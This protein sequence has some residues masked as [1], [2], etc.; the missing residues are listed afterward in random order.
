M[1]RIRPEEPEEAGVAPETPDLAQLEAARTLAND[2]RPMLKDAG[3][4]DDQI[5]KW[6]ETYIA[7]EGSG[8]VD[9]FVAWIR[10]LQE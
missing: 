1:D 2:A 8:D 6:A 5:E 9:T 4:D 3:F 10:D 7:D